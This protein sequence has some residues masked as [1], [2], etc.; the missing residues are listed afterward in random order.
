M[1]KLNLSFANKSFC[2]LHVSILPNCLKMRL[3]FNSQGTLVYQSPS[4][5]QYH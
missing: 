5:W 1:L 3:K 4:Y 2:T